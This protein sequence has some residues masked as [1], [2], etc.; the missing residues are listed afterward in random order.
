[1]L[2]WVLDPTFP[3]GKVQ[4]GRRG[5]WTQR[6]GA[7]CPQ[8]PSRLGLRFRAL[9]FKSLVFILTY[10]ALP[11]S[12]SHVEK[13]ALDQKL[14]NLGS[15]PGPA[16]QPTE[17][18]GQIHPLL[19]GPQF[20]GLSSGLAW[21]V[22]KDQQCCSSG[23]PPTLLASGRDPEGLLPLFCALPLL[24]GRLFAL[25]F[26]PFSSHQSPV[27]DVECCCSGVGSEARGRQR[28]LYGARVSMG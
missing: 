9:E 12:D 6:A 27:V 8:S 24:S 1:M 5:R 19:L 25:S 2:G 4:G 7:S 18:H 21:M 3:L 16:T 14:R 23:A 28:N 15:S 13:R 17:T 26:L 10:L 22:S 11:M 20:L